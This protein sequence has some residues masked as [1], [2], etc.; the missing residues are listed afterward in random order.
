MNKA[1]YIQDVARLKTLFAKASRIYK[2]KEGDPFY[3]IA[4]NA[5]AYEIVHEVLLECARVG[6]TLFSPSTNLH[7]DIIADFIENVENEYMNEINVDELV[8]GYGLSKNHFTKVFKQAVNL[9]PHDYVVDY[10]IEKAK[11]LL[12]EGKYYINEIAEMVGYP[13]Y[14]YFSRLFKKKEGVSPKNCI[15]PTN[16]S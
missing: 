13:D 1:I 15:K 11:A 16:K 2:R 10:R 4:L 12:Q 6:T 3:Q 8:S 7:E 9:T 14:A 5:C